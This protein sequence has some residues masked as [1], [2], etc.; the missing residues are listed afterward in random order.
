MEK[1][2]LELGCD[3]LI[4]F[5]T[6]FLAT[7]TEYLRRRIGNV[8]LEKIRHELETKQELAHIAVKFAEQAWHDFN[9]QKKFEE[10]A[11]W[12]AA[13]AQDK[14]IKATDSEIKALIEFALREIKDH[15]GE[16]WVE[17]TLPS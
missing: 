5:I 11:G 1:T 10:A 4:V 13:Q 8:K 7:I 9:G 15:L 2:L 12:L 6:F 3:I 16:A 14:G 17:K